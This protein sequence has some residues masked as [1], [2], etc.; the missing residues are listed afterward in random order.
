MHT[1]VHTR[2]QQNT[3]TNTATPAADTISVKAILL[4]GDGAAPQKPAGRQS[5]YHWA[6]FI[7]RQPIPRADLHLIL[8][9]S[10][11]SNYPA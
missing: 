6:A 1:Y 2:S 11:E 9:H 7:S 5:R 4:L 8:R 3:Y 10:N